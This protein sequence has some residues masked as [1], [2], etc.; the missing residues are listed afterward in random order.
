MEKLAVNCDR[1]KKLTTAITEFIAR[2]L[3]PIATVDG[4]GFLN[5]MQVAE[6]QYV[7]PCRA[8]ITGHVCS[9]QGESVADLC[10]TAPCIPH[11]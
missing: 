1:T 7:V 9:L 6:P 8:T 10:C 2:D 3:R 4:T 5:L 11:H